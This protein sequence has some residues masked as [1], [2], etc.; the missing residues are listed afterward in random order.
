MKLCLRRSLRHAWDILNA[1]PIDFA[2][3]YLSFTLAPLSG[4]YILLAEGPILPGDYNADEVVDAADYAVWRDNF[5]SDNTLPNDDTDGVDQDDYDRWKTNF[6]RSVLGGSGSSTDT[7]VPE[8]ATLVMVFLGLASTRA[9]EKLGGRRG[10][11]SRN[12]GRLF[13]T[14]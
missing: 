7:A 1:E 10:D 13:R 2:G 6:G 14:A 11:S 3:D 4:R 12:I 5:G 9:R 8:P